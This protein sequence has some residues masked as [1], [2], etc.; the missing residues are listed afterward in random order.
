MLIQR[1]FVEEN[2]VKIMIQHKK[3]NISSVYF[4]LLLIH[5]FFKVQK[6]VLELTSQ[7]VINLHYGLLFSL[8]MNSLEFR[9]FFEKYL[10]W[11]TLNINGTII[12]LEIKTYQ[13]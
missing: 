6:D 4:F 13:D 11:H 2:T 9:I 8:L 12:T 10:T 5:S 1:H 7:Q 3:K